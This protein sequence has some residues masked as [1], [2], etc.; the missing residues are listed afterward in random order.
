M[1]YRISDS[2]S[3]FITPISPDFALALTFLQKC[4]KKAGVGTPMSLSLAYAVRILVGRFIF[5]IIW[6]FLGIPLGPGSST[7]YEVYLG[8]R[9]LPGFPRFCH[10]VNHRLQP[11]HLL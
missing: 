3:N 6:Y 2:P 9:L 1:L 7:G 4:Y 11:E 5:F 8:A 10:L